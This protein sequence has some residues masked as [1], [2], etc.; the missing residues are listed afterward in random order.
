MWFVKLGALILTLILLI[1]YPLYT[2]GTAVFFVVVAYAIGDAKIKDKTKPSKAQSK[3][4]A[5]NKVEIPEFDAMK[6]YIRM[7]ALGHSN[8]AIIN[9]EGGLGKSFTTIETLKEIN[10]DY[11]LFTGYSTLLSFYKFLY[12]NRDKIIVLDDTEG[13]LK[14]VRAIGL[15]KNALWE[16]D[17]RRQVE[18]N[19]STSMLKDTPE[20]FDFTGRI[21]FLCNQ[22]PNEGKRNMEALL[23]RALYYK[24]AFTFEQ[25]MK[26][27][28]KCISA[29]TDLDPAQKQKIWDIL[30]RYLTSET[31]NINFRLV[32]RLAQFVKFNEAMAEKLFVELYKEEFFNV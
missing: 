10:A 24:I 29:R 3:S 19:S 25:K 5:M 15:L 14:D 16:V 26:I 20:S 8:C 28:K 31:N 6:Q 7:T 21:I 18:Y 4:P 17:G 23:S 27:L 2:V 32:E 12:E 13:L 9:G 1:N 22:I 11:A 30:N